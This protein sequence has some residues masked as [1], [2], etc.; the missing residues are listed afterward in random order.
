MAG[1]CRWHQGRASGQDG[2]GLSS[3]SLRVRQEQ[4]RQRYTPSAERQERRRGRPPQTLR[5]VPAAKRKHFSEA[6]QIGYHYLQ[7]PDL[8]CDC[9]C[10]I[11]D[12]EYQGES[13]Q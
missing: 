10:H 6:C 8:Q 12:G 9:T 3:P 4:M 1:I 7:C 11:A 2:R 13:T 5:L